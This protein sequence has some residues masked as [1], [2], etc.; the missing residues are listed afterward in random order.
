MK[1]I[2]R[3]HDQFLDL[4][5]I[6][7]ARDE[8][9]F[10]RNTI[11]SIIAQTI[12]PIEWIIVDDG[13][14]DGTAEIVEEYSTRYEW[15]HLVRK[16]DRG[17][18]IVGS[19][20]IEAFNYGMAQARNPDYLYLAKFDADIT[21][22]PKYIEIM[23]DKLESDPKLAAVAGKTFRPE[24]D[25]LVEE[26]HIDEMVTGQF[27][28]YKREAFEAIGG[29]DESPMWDAIDMYRCR[30]LGWKTCSFHHPE[31]YI[32]HHRQMGASDRNIY[33]GYWRQGRNRYYI[34]YHPIYL[35]VSSVFRMHEK[36][37]ILGGLTTIISYCWH[38]L[39]R[40][41]RYHDAALRR[42]VREWQAQ[43]LKQ[44]LTTSWRKLSG[45]QRDAE[46]R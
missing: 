33:V 45:M 7:T 31:A 11:D 6:T 3:R 27:K 24:G 22:P 26:P 36:P 17:H 29:F 23:L 9:K 42:S 2:D 21:L 10:I 19:G 28:F 8:A 14:T 16:P 25:K 1:E 38:V 4:L 37:W 43:R 40:A 39:K 18:R 30:M 32:I 15:I 5:A 34:G 46:H 44:L 13:S 41:E 12:W 20:V 35:L